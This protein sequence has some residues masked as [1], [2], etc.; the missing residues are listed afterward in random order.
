V[1]LGKDTGYRVG[2]VWL[3]IVHQYGSAVYRTVL[4]NIEKTSPEMERKDCLENANQNLKLEGNM[5]V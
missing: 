4:P 2:F 5:F 3:A 1:K